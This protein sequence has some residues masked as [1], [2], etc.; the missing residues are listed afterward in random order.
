MTDT[1]DENPNGPDTND[2]SSS[3][4]ETSEPDVDADGFEDEPLRDRIASAPKPAMIWAAGF[5]VLVAVQFGAIAGAVVHGVPWST[6]LGPLPPLP[7]S[8]MVG[9]IG[10][11]AAD[12]P[13]LTSP[14]V[15]PNEGYYVPSA[16]WQGT[17]LGLS[18]AVA[19]G[20]RAVLVYVYAFTF[21]AWIGYAFALHRR[22]YRYADWTPRDDV[23]GRL[24]THRWGQFGIIIVLAFVVMAVFA[25][26]LA[27]APVEQNIEN[28]YTHTIEYYDEDAGEVTETTAG[29]ANRDSQ[30]RGGETNIGPMAYDEYDRFHP[31]G[32]MPSGQD[33]FTFMVFGA[34]VSLLIGM[35]S[36]GI[37]GVTAAAFALFGAYYKGA[38]DLSFVLLSDSV[39]AMP[40][41]L[42]LVLLSVVL[43]DTW[44]GGLYSGAIIL[45]VIFGVTGWPA[46]WRA[47]RGPALQVAEREWIDAARSYGQKPTKTMRKHMLPYIL[48]YLLIYA[49]MTLGGIIVGV[50]G[51]S[52]L[53][54]GVDSPTPEWGRAIDAGQNYV[55]TS[56]WHISLLP[57]LFIVLVVTAFNALGDGIRDAIDPQ[58]NVGGDAE[59]AAA[60][61]TGA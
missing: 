20:V 34:R 1:N 2:G 14:D 51:L 4:S 45:A 41:L 59:E 50:A 22:H 42:L 18:P 23:L 31:L 47:V 8:N 21:L 55:T 37:S 17:F 58:S 32:T 29:D 5:A 12:L 57:G 7:G 36:L 28:P 43:A 53:G 11:W 48:G 40:R 10:G 49:S 35:L 3:G 38:L 61:G 46:L 33:L 39:Q 25:P 27:T 44:L 13:T 60:G 6:L 30:S 54:L 26:A 15:I 19:W 56:S 16:G 52:F 9:T 24:R